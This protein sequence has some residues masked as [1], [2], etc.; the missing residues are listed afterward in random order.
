MAS[1]RRL[2][3]VRGNSKT[4]TLTFT[5]NNG[6]PYCL[7]GWVVFFTLKQNAN[8]P[9]SEASLQK[10]V[11]QFADSTSGTSGVASIGILP[12]DTENL[13]VR[14]Y[15][16]DIAVRT[17]ENEVFTVARGKFDLEYNIT[18]TASTAGTAG[19]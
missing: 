9:D 13:D 18:R 12:T 16:Y 14:E 15:E 17:A 10:I 1:L 3:L 19:T 7:R 11:T 8:L 4:Y 6:V 5:R 2:S